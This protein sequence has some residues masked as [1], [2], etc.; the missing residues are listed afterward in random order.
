MQDDGSSAV[1]LL[2]TGSSTEN[3]QKYFKIIK[4]L[5]KGFS[6][7]L[8]HFR[9]LY[10]NKLKPLHVTVVMTTYCVTSK[11]KKMAPFYMPFYF[12]LA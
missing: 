12:F 8:L 7:A 4:K 9:Q 6:A 10:I 2:R 3:A 5:N 1:L 11:S